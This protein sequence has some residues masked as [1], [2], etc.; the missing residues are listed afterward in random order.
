[1]KNKKKNNNIKIILILNVILGIL[2]YIIPE[3]II[4]LFLIGIIMLIVTIMST[5]SLINI[6]KSDKKWD[7]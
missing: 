6:Y 2:V 1:M 7:M 3:T 5:I 4:T